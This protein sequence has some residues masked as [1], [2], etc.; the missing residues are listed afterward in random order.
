[1]QIQKLHIRPLQAIVASTLGRFSARISSHPGASRLTSKEPACAIQ[2]AALL[3]SHLQ[4]QKQS[5]RSMDIPPSRGPK[6]IPG[7][8][9]TEPR[10]TPP[11]SRVLI[12]NETRL[13]QNSF[14]VSA[15]PGHDQQ[16]HASQAE[17]QLR[18]HQHPFHSTSR[19]RVHVCRPLFNSHGTASIPRPRVPAQAAAESS[20]PSGVPSTTPEQR[21]VPPRSPEPRSPDPDARACSSGYGVTGLPMIK[22]KQGPRSKWLAA[23]V[24]RHL[25][26][27]RACVERRRRWG[28]AIPRI[29]C[30]G[31]KVSVPDPAPGGG[32]RRSPDRSSRSSPP[33]PPLLARQARRERISPLAGSSPA[34]AGVRQLQRY[35]RSRPGH[36]PPRSTAASSRS[37]TLSPPREASL[38][39]TRFISAASR[40]GADQIAVGGALGAHTVRCSPSSAASASRIISARAPELRDRRCARWMPYRLVRQLPRRAP[41]GLRAAVS[42]V[43]DHTGSHRAAP[44]IVVQ[45]S[46]VVAGCRGQTLGADHRRRRLA[47]RADGA[48]AGRVATSRVFISHDACGAASFR[49]TGWPSQQALRY[50]NFFGME[51]SFQQDQCGVN[52]STA[53]PTTDRPRPFSFSDASHKLQKAPL[54]PRQTA[55]IR[56]ES[57]DRRSPSREPESREDF[58]GVGFHPFRRNLAHLFN[59]S[60]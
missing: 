14:Q 47:P 58:S 43:C 9:E 40:R 8:R 45:L 5:P 3:G 7:T 26:S 54:N 6:N 39:V 11:A 31:N 16:R 36:A 49:A 50:N 48:T 41:E 25:G 2:Q 4:P 32:E 37:T 34:E 51:P 52:R 12:L 55:R 13:L 19:P 38:A 59:P 57:T 35:P 29:R 10:N 17:D 20:V 22:I 21:H 33:H 44:A 28:R 27:R 42:S 24:R 15:R 60:K 46:R 1:M 23:T 56:G 53:R 18:I 30:R